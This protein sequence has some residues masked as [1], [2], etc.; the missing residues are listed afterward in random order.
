MTA[1]GD[2][3]MHATRQRRLV[4][5]LTLLAGVLALAAGCA[6]KGRNPAAQEVSTA[7]GRPDTGVTAGPTGEA[8]QGT[9][10]R[11]GLD[12]QERRR[13]V[14]AARAAFLATTDQTIAYT[15]VPQNIDAEPTAVSAKPAGPRENRAD[16]STCRPI[17]LSETKQGRTTSGTL[18]FC[19]AAGTGDIRV[20]P[21][22]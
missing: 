4:L 2:H 6:G 7:V 12:D 20:S 13:L 11:L 21:T 10:A 15:V 14:E 3:T 19:Q 9:G 22:I 5:T 8:P 1:G 18:T 17:Q 16:G